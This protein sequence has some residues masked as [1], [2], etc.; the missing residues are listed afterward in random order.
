MG[1]G[2]RVACLGVGQWGRNLARN[3][4]V[5]DALYAIHDPDAARATEAAATHAGV[6]LAESVDAVLS[7]P[8]VD[9]V[10]IAT[11]VETHGSLVRRALEAGKD[12]FVEKPMAL[13]TAECDRMVEAAR[14][15]NRKLFVG[16]VLPFVPEY[17]EA[18]RIIGEGRHG[19]L[20]SG[21]FKRVISDPTWLKDFW[22]P[23]TV[24]G[25]LVDLHVHDAHLIRLL[26]GMPTAVMSQGRM[27]G[28]VVE[29][30][31]TMFRF[32]DPSLVVSAPSGVINQQGRAFTHG[33]EI[34]LEKATM[35]FEFAVVDGKPKLLLP[36]TLYEADGSVRQPDVGDGDP[37]RAFEGEIEEVAG[38]LAS[39]RPSPVLSGDL[40]RD[41]LRICHAQTE[42]VRS[43]REA[44][45]G[46]E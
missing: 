8:A 11:P 14:K 30:C 33:F 21:S 12:V 3:F 2:V 42:S 31:N 38:A 46:P 29:Y 4:A 5:L 9:A 40:A 27:R 17:R 10:A 1:A 24:G 16:H 26:F 43:G 19:K 44:K 6:R 18:R 37:V 7:D 25:P 39:G 45:I 22:D 35:Q 41:A 23:R 20:L 28:D 15:A 13:T 36:L 32:A 34:H